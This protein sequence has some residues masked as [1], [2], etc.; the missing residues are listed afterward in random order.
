MPSTKGTGQSES[1]P[2]KQEGLRAIFKQHLAIC[3]RGL[4]KRHWANSIYHYIDMNAGSGHNHDIDCEGS[5]LVFWEMVSILPIKHKA[6]LIEIEP[7]NVN[8]LI[9][10][11]IDWEDCEILIGDNSE[12]TPRLLRQLPR[13]T[14]GILYH[15]P[16]GIPDFELL[17]NL[18][19]M[20]QSSR[21]DFLIRCPATAIK[22]NY[23]QCHTRLIEHIETIKK[24]YWIIRELESGC[25]W[26][27]TFLLGLNTNK[28]K[29]WESQGFHYIH[30]KRGQEI[31]RQLN[32]TKDELSE[33]NQ[34]TLF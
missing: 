34:P 11:T 31:I 14:F 25:R 20:H 30:S 19:R 28:V 12:W 16:N 26:Q 27:W 4:L 10:R 6:F 21:L 33:L 18:S 13:N 17:A 1:T 29:A 5:P 23:H 7:T 2:L 15:D 24:K 3:S 9:D 8:L 22:R 32:Y